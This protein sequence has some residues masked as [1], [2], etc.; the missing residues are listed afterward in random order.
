MIFCPLLVL[1]GCGWVGKAMDMDMAIDAS[2]G[3]QIV[4][5]LSGYGDGWFK[6]VMNG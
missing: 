3:L 1:K 4:R 6:K 5:N 2:R